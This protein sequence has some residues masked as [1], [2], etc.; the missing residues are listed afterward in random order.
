MKRIKNDG[1]IIIVCLLHNSPGI[2]Q[3]I[4]TLKEADVLEGGFNA[5]FTPDLQEVTVT[6]RQMILLLNLQRGS[7]DDVRCAESGGQGK[8]AVGFILD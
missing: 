3:I 2:G 7:G 6:F 8:S 5:F 1:R 4:Y